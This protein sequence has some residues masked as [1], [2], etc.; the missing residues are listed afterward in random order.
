MCE[1]FALS[2]EKKKD[3]T[4]LLEEFFSH[5][6]EH[7]H[8]WGTATFEGDHPHIKKEALPSV[9]SALLR[10]MLSNPVETDLLLAHIRLATKGSIEYVNTHPFVRMD[11]EG[12]YWTLIHNGTIFES[13]HL[14]KYIHVQ[15]GFTDSERI[16]FFLVDS[17]AKKRQEKKRPLSDR[18][19]FELTE[20]MIQDI[21]PENKLNLLFCDGKHLFVHSNFRGSL[22]R[23]RT[24]KSICISTR[25]LEEQGWKEVPLNTL[26]VYR[27]GDLVYQGRP[28]SEEFFETEEKMKFLFLDYAGI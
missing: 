5:G 23:K 21:A 19:L 6:Y 4:Q 25:P 27:E 13:G 22:H 12:R 15:E 9:S 10:N 8:G 3:C 24:D 20:K 2:S 26:L 18:D 7:P 14:E 1:L 28:H 17:I 16:L 11:C